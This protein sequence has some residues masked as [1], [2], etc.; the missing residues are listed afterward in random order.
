MLG[1]SFAGIPATL[2]L[3]DLYPSAGAEL[4]VPETQE[5][6]NPTEP[7]NNA[8]SRAVIGM[9]GLPPAIVW[10]LFAV[11]LLVAVKVIT[12]KVGG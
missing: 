3:R 5:K 11:G 6:T 1:G 8:A 2:T 12:E 4:S 7:T 9:V 10:I